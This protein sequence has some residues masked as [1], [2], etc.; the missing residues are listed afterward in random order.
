MNK[1]SFNGSPDGDMLDMLY[2]LG[3]LSERC[4]VASLVEFG[5]SCV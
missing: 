1:F 2:K 3:I 4:C 5:V